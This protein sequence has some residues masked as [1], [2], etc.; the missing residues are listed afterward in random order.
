MPDIIVTTPLGRMKE[1]A[2][3]AEDSIH[4]YLTTGEVG[5]YFRQ[6][7][8]RDPRHHP[9][10]NEGNRVYY[11]EDGYIRGYMLVYSKQFR[12]SGLICQT[13]GSQYEPGLYIYYL[14]D[15]WHWIKPIPMQGFQGFRYANWVWSDQ[16]ENHIL[17]KVDGVI[18]EVI[19]I[20]DWLMP[21]PEVEAI[22][23]NEEKGRK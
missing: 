23:I 9:N 20:G 15:S 19:N 21:Y 7:R 3:E 16:S 12:E 1:A 14:A 18:Y 22:T 2:Q 6:F 10:V 5:F 11:V 8:H 4:E 13:T 17:L